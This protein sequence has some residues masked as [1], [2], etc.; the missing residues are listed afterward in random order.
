MKSECGE[1]NNDGDK[2]G[3]RRSVRGGESGPAHQWG[4]R[5]LKDKLVNNYL[6]GTDQYPNTYEK[7]MRILGNYQ[8]TKTNRPF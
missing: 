2:G 6:L 3:R 7:A 4:E 1:A 5:Q 8:T